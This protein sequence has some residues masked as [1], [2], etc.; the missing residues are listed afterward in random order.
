MKNRQT[1]IENEIR[2]RLASYREEGE[3]TQEVRERLVEDYNLTA[4]ESY[5]LVADS[6]E[7]SPEAALA[8]VYSVG[9][10]LDIVNSVLVFENGYAPIMLKELVFVKS[11]LIDALEDFSGYDITHL[12]NHFHNHLT[13]G[14]N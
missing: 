11:V 12:L 3:S 10:S 9:Q 1:V 4:Y 13:G 6:V 7:E 5:K 8:F 2:T 14:I